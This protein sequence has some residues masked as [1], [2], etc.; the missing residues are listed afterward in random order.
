MKESSK[1]TMDRPTKIALIVVIVIFAV[2]IVIY[3]YTM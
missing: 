2:L 3:N 1:E